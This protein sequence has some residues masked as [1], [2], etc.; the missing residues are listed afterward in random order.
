MVLNRCPAKRGMKIMGDDFWKDYPFLST[1]GDQNRFISEVVALAYGEDGSTVFSERMRRRRGIPSAIC[2]GS[3]WKEMGQPPINTYLT[4]G[5]ISSYYGISYETL[6]VDR[7]KGRLPKPLRIG[8]G[9]TDYF[10]VNTCD[11]CPL[12]Q[13]RSKSRTTG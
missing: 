3:L 6:R 5:G 1:H 8:N 13:Y 11:D 12:I 9:N 7:K 4:L 10:G 2:P